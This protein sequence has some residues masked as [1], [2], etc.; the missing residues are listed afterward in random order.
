MRSRARSS[1]FG[2]SA[3]HEAMC[4]WLARHAIHIL[5]PYSGVDPTPA[6]Q[7]VWA[8]DY[9][10]RLVTLWLVQDGGDVADLRRVAC[11]KVFPLTKHADDAALL[12]SER[13]KSNMLCLWRREKIGPAGVR[14]LTLKKI[15]TVVPANDIVVL[16]DGDDELIAPLGLQHINNAYIRYGAWCTY[17]SYVGQFSEQT[18]K[19]PENE[20][21]APRYQEWRYGHARTFKVFL[22]DHAYE[23]DFFNKI[24]NDWL[25][26]ATDRALFLRF[27]EVSGRHRVHLVNE[28]VYLYK[29]NPQNSRH[30][31]PIEQQASDLNHVLSSEPS[32]VIDLPLHV[33][34][35]IYGRIFLLASQIDSMASQ[36]ILKQHSLVV[37]IINNN[38]QEHA[39]VEDVI[40]EAR[41]KH[42]GMNIKLSHSSSNT[43]AFGRFEYVCGL[44]ESIPME[45]VIFVDDDQLWPQHFFEALV[46]AL[47]PS[48]SASW[49][50]KVFAVTNGRDQ[51]DYWHSTLTMNDIRHHLR[52]DVAYFKYSGPGGSAFDTS[53]CL[54]MKTLE[55]L[56]RQLSKYAQHDDIWVSFVMDAVLGRKQRR[57]MHPIPQDIA[58]DPDGSELFIPSDKLQKEV[59]EISTYSKSKAIKSEFFTYLQLE[60]NWNLT[61]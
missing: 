39:E 28:A 27:L 9:D 24:T 55:I 5:V 61:V 12:R 20:H 10:H 30:T 58:F 16:L 36:T 11:N 44:R 54:A 13:I 47:S 21:F 43:G 31:I 1:T 35:V 57:L 17:G 6:I 14:F 59:T 2:F 19:I 53:I 48:T 40:M 4:P 56:P 51:Q 23:H 29:D 32:S 3:Q 52:T 34:L 60:L 46:E 50:G 25:Q 26:K 45:L 18:T 38:M 8:Q 33:V 22:I 37:H 15:R 49:Y 7:S 41:D 42:P